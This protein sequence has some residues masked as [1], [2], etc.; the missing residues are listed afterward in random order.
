MPGTAGTS[1]KLAE[2]T[3]R[4][5]TGVATAA[6][7]RVTLSVRVTAPPRLVRMMEPW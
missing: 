5:T 7:F 3:M 6:T 1:R 2:F 4:D